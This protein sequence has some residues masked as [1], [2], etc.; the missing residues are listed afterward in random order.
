MDIHV[1][2]HNDSEKLD[3]ILRHLERIGDTIMATLAELQAAATGIGTAVA[4]VGTDVTAA[5]ADIQALQASGTGGIAPADLDP[6]VAALTTATTSLTA[7][8]TSLEAVLPAPA[9][10]KPAP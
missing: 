6:V 5:I 8:A 2:I 4:K 9:A 7:A 3:R 10:P 1:Y